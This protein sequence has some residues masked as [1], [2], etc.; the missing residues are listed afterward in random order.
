ML[1]RS[2][3]L[4]RF[5]TIGIPVSEE[6]RLKS[7]KVDDT[8]EDISDYYLNTLKDMGY[9]PLEFNNK[10]SEIEPIYFEKV[11]VVKADYEEE[12][13]E[14]MKFRTH[15]L[16]HKAYSAFQ[17]IPDEVHKQVW[18]KTNNYAINKYGSDYRNIKYYTK[19]MASYNVYKVR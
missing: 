14:F 16:E 5:T 11:K 8:Y 15:R 17:N 19:Y 12:F 6:L 9:R 18:E 13:T 2:G 4:V 1:F 10:S 3:I 7:R